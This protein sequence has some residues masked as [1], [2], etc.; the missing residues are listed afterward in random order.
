M[1]NSFAFAAFSGRLY[2]QQAAR[3]GGRWMQFCTIFFGVMW[4]GMWIVAGVIAAIYF[5]DKSLLQGSHVVGEVLQLDVRPY[6]S[7]SL[8]YVTTVTY[9]FSLPDGRRFTRT[10]RRTLGSPPGLQRGGP[11]DVLY[12]PS[13]PDHSTISKEFESTMA[14]KPLVG[15]M[16]FLL[17]I[18]PALYI[19]RYMQWRRETR[20][21]DSH[22]LDGG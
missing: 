12:E 9:A 4:A 10:T 13:N 17:G 2:A 16:F 14:E 7:K 8:E 6:R 19:Y 3:Y 22:G 18:Y 1:V 21:L 5:T 11:I 20:A 15:W